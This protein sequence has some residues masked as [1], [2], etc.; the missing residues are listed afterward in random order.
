ML[1]EANN[2]YIAVL[3]IG[4]RNSIKLERAEVDCCLLFR[5]TQAGPTASGRIMFQLQ[6]A[7]STLD[8]STLDVLRD[9]EDEVFLPK[10]IFMYRS[11]SYPCLHFTLYR[12]EHNG[13]VKDV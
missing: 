8:L 11:M 6:D 13:I 1:S 12:H 5:E 2:S 3:P 7:N 10:Q 4:P 9:G